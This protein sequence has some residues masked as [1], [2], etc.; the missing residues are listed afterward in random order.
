MSSIISVIITQFNN[1]MD[2]EQ[3]PKL[4]TFHSVHDCNMDILIRSGWVSLS[5][6]LSL[7]LCR[8]SAW[9]LPW[10]QSA[11]YG[12]DRLAVA[13]CKIPPPPHEPGSLSI[14]PPPSLSLPPS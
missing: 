11:Q 14:D 13:T 5:L 8:P 9:S 6:S 12:I 2:Q 10:L 1:C 3:T 4:Q 7:S